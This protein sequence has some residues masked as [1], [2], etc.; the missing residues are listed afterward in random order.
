[1]RLAVQA[2]E[3]R[4]EE[5]ARREIE[6]PPDLLR[7]LPQDLAVPLELREEREVDHLNVDRHFRVGYA[8]ELPADNRKRALEGRVTPDDFIEGLAENARIE[9]SLNTNGQEVNPRKTSL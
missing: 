6:G 7:R 2:Q 1:V 9:R 8:A 3:A 4:A 5:R